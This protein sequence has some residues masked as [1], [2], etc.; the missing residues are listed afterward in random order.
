MRHVGSSFRP[1][2]AAW[3]EHGEESFTF[4]DAERLAE[5]VSPLRRG[6]LLKASSIQ[7]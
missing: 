7:E 5:D 6:D 4:E 3:Q 1:L 2:Q